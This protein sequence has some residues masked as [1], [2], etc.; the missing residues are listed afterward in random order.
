MHLTAL[1]R[2]LYVSFVT[3][4]HD[5]GDLRRIV[6]TSRVNNA[7]TGITGCLMQV[8]DCFIQVLEGR[9]EDIEPV[10]EKICCDFRHRDVRLIDFVAVPE[11]VFP[12]WGMGLIDGG[13]HTLLDE[14]DLQEVKFLLSIN[15]REAI[16]KMQALLGE[17]STE[18]TALAA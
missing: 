4:G 17:S 3:E 16:R 7:R 13:D 15:A 14:G 9:G 6:E 8:D 2:L 11:R 12:G 10:F 18:R 5:P 1:H